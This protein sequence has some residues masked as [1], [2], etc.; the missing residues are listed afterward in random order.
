M[1]KKISTLLGGLLRLLNPKSWGP[2]IEIY[3]QSKFDHGV[4]LSWSQGGEDLALIPLLKDI[5]H[6]RYL[7]I[8][9]HH[10]DRFSVTRALYQ[11]GWTGVNVEAN[12]NL[13]GEFLKRRPRDKTLSF[14]VG[15]KPEYVLNVFSEPAISTVSA[16]WTE[17]FLSESQ[18][19]VD[20]IAV[21]G[22]SLNTL[23]SQHFPKKGPD[24]LV[25]DV[26]GL[27][28]E[29]IQSLDPKN[30]SF[31]QLPTVIVVETP[32]GVEEVITS[33]IYSSLLEIGYKAM[34]ILPMST[35]F[36]KIT[37]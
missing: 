14:A 3:S 16:E 35:I 23:I 19:I 21:K 29:V 30:L 12:P 5:E 28:F 17:R 11:K 25:V 15:L 6:G 36:K 27:D 4:S 22:I 10:P 32:Y 13:I 7:D 31:D 37:H 8:G 34:C 2:F 1:I 9:A 33:P 24:L 26:E 18:T 20:E